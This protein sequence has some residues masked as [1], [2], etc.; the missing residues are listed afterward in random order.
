M[1]SSKQTAGRTWNRDPTYK[2]NMGRVKSLLPPTCLRHVVLHDNMGVERRLGETSRLLERQRA[3]TQKL[4]SR[5][6]KAFI[7]RQLIQQQL[8]QADAGQHRSHQQPTVRLLPADVSNQHRDSANVVLRSVF[9]TGG[10]DLPNHHRFR[11]LLARHNTLEIIDQLTASDDQPIDKQVPTAMLQ[12][13][14]HHDDDDDMLALPGNRQAGN[15]ENKQVTS[16]QDD[17]LNR[18][19]YTLNDQLNHQAHTLNDQL[20]HQAHTLHDGFP[21]TQLKK[22]PPIENPRHQ[23]T[24]QQAAT[25][26]QQTHS[27]HKAVTQQTHSNHNAVTQQTHSNHNAVTQQTHN[28]HNAVT[29]QSHAKATQLT[30][31]KPKLK[32]T[33]KQETNDAERLQTSDVMQRGVP[34]QHRQRAVSDPRFVALQRSLEDMSVN[35]AT[36]PL[37][38]IAGNSSAHEGAAAVSANQQRKRASEADGF[39]MLSSSNHHVPRMTSA[40]R[41]TMRSK[42]LPAI[43]PHLDPQRIHNALAAARKVDDVYIIT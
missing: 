39:V 27:N 17:E 1:K 24:G 7:V 21:V 30:I 35:E 36:S 23:N 4:Y 11:P 10:K 20:N 19:S 34:R 3:W 40:Q 33:S 32:R 8:S 12:A 26:T 6:R 5:R 43:K 2:P 22:L 37:A 31:A 15:T 16:Y 13:V 25:V 28:H 42:Y 38:D 9:Y 14:H 18:Q 41:R 29:Q